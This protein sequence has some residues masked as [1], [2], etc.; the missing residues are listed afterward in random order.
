DVGVP[1][2][3]AV[4]DDRSTR[5]DVDREDERS[6]IARSRLAHIVIRAKRRRITATATTTST[7]APTRN[8][9]CGTSMKKYSW[10]SEWSK[11][12]AF[13]PSRIVF[14]LMRASA[15]PIGLDP[16]W[17]TIPVTTAGRIRSA[18][19]PAVA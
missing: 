4:E 6:G 8:V 11:K 15:V 13:V 5:V 3:H 7:I 17:I 10:P 16:I 2:R 12:R 19:I 18:M 14:G 9:Q 1:A